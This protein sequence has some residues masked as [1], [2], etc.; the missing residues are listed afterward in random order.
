MALLERTRT[1]DTARTLDRA[2]VHRWSVAEVFVTDLRCGGDPVETVEAVAQWPRHHA[3]FDTGDGLHCLLLGAETF[4]QTAIAALHTAGVAAQTD[5]FVMKHMQVRWS[6]EPPAVGDRPLDLRVTMAMT[7]TGRAGR[8]D[9]RVSLASAEREVLT[10]T[11]VV[12]VLRPEVFDA[13]RQGRVEPR[14]R[15]DP[16][17]AVGPA[18]VGRTRPRDVVLAGDGPPWQL[19]VDTSHPTLF[20]HPSDHL[21]GML[22]FEAARQA[23]VLVSG[24]GQVVSIG[25]EFGAYLEI[26][27]TTT[28]EVGTDDGALVATVRQGDLVGARF[29]VSVAP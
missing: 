10:G 2:L 13:L 6:G 8:Y 27:A 7:P 5:H 28:V 16:P 20:D 15:V 19:R 14:S 4:R 12:I 25:A 23:A 17:S 29:R 26:D 24:G 21:P 3:Y 9:L 22:L 18:E 1:L 11:G